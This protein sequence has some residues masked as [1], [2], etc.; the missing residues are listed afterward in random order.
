M[1]SENDFFKQKSEK[2]AAAEA[3][4]TMVAV[5]HQTQERTR[6]KNHKISTLDET[7]F[8]SFLSFSLQN[9]SSQKFQKCVE[10]YSFNLFS[11]TSNSN[12][13]V[14]VLSSF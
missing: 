13:I 12:L 3:R 7:A 10:E 1:E 14:I 6:D 4:T 8:A 11:F 5:V 2:L 9:I